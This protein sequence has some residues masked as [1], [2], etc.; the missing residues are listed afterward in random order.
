MELINLRL[1]NPCPVALE[2]AGPENKHTPPTEGVR[3]SWG[4]GL[5][6]AKE[7]KEIE[8]PEG[9]WVGGGLKKNPF[10]GGG[11]DILWNYTM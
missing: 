8:F 9:G 3:I 5:C 10:R 11:M 7:I 1:K 6:K 2:C 4:W